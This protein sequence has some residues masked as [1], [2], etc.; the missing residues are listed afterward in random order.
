MTVRSK[1]S[2]GGVSLAGWPAPVS[3]RTQPADAS[4]PPLR[5]VGVPGELGMP[6]RNT[7]P[8]PADPYAAMAEQIYKGN[9]YA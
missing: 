4:S 3:L 5:A 6:Y 8:M 2:A 1:G 9:K 7:G